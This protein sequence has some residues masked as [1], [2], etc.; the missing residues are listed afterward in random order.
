MEQTIDRGNSEA[1]HSKWTPC[2]YFWAGKKFSLIKFLLMLLNGISFITINGEISFE[3]V[4]LDR[5][6]LSTNQSQSYYWVL[7]CSFLLNPQLCSVFVGYC[8]CAASQF[9]LRSI[10]LYKFNWEVKQIFRFSFSP[11]SY[12]WRANIPRRLMKTIFSMAKLITSQVLV[13]IP[14]LWAT[15]VRMA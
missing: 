1:I 12:V 15:L 9:S 3:Y 8:T 10:K 7:Y 13:T 14:R 5:A 4:I 2:C 6:I 11:H